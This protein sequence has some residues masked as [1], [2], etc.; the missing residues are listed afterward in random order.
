MLWHLPIIYDNMSGEKMAFANK[1][2]QNMEICYVWCH[3]NVLGKEFMCSDKDKVIL[4]FNT[5]KDTTIISS[6]P[7]C[8]MWFYSDKTKW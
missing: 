7:C 4:I 2:E 6:S 8:H 1:R 5:I 3:C